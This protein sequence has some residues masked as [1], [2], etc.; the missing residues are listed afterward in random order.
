MSKYT[1]QAHERAAKHATNADLPLLNA[2]V[3]GLGQN[4]V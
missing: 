4:S 2:S 1:A 3:A